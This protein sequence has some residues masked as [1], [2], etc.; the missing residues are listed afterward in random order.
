M[1][2]L[3]YRMREIVHLQTGQVSIALGPVAVVAVVLI[4]I[5]YT[6]LVRKPDRYVPPFP[7]GLVWPF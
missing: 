6:C 5:Q 2:D 7:P 3:G 1:A 4:I